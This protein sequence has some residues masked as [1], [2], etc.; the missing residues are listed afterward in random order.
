VGGEGRVGWVEVDTQPW[1]HAA[2]AAAALLGLRSRDPGVVERGHAARRVVPLLLLPPRV[3][4]QP[5]VREGDRCLGHVG[6]QHHLEEAGLGLGFR[7]GVGARVR[8][9]VR[10]RVG[11]RVRARV[12]VGV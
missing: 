7:V 1:P 11:V 8:V 10:V 12:R 2:R 6:R 5:D 4:D 3:D 9:R